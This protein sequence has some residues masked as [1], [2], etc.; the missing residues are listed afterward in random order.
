MSEQEK[1]KKTYADVLNFINAASVYAKES[2]ENFLTRAIAKLRPALMKIVDSYNEL[3]D[4]IDRKY[5][6]VTNDDYKTILRDEKG[7]YRFTPENQGKRNKEVG[8]LLNTKVEIPVHIIAKDR[9]PAVTAEQ[10][11]LFAGFVLPEQVFDDEETTLKVVK[12]VPAAEM[13]SQN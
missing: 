3:L 12:D 9:T 8:K 2:K 5:C 4:D 10:Q 1:P 11:T 7:N 6:T 13:E